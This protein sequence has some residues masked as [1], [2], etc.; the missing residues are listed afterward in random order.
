MRFLCFQRQKYGEGGKTRYTTPV[1]KTMT[2]RYGPVT[3]VEALSRKRP[4]L[5]TGAHD[6]GKSRWLERLHTEA[7]GI[8][9]KK[10]DAPALW[11][12]ALRPLSAWSDVDHV[13]EW[14]GRRAAKAA[15]K[16]AEEGRQPGPECRP[17]LRVKAWERSEALPDY[18]KETGAVLF[19]DDCHKLTGRKLQIARE[20]ALAARIWVA[21]AS[22]EPRIPPNLRGVLM[23]RD[24]QIFRLDSEVAYDATNIFVWCLALA[25]LAAGAWEAGAAVAGLKALASGR[26]ASRQDA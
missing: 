1:V 2:R 8:W 16:A 17:W 21:A 10:T 25:L 22:E 4:V 14:W 11:L 20:C 24:P 19:L 18:L 12:G 23:R 3:D 7:P 15:E 13:A 5:V 6:S 26:R 9:G